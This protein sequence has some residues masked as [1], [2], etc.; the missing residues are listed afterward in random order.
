MPA[1]VI[2]NWTFLQQ[3]LW[4][5]TLMFVMFLLSLGVLA[6]DKRG[7]ARRIFWYSVVLL[8]GVVYNPYFWF[9]F[10]NGVYEGDDLVQLRLPWMVPALLIMAYAMSR[11]AFIAKKWQ[12]AVGIAAGFV[13][14][15]WWAGVPFHP[16]VVVEKENVYK[17]S[18]DAKESADAVLKDMKENPEHLKERPGLMEFNSTDYYDDIT[19]ANL[20]HYGIRQ[21]TSAFTV[22]PALVTEETY[23]QEGFSVTG[24][25]N[26]PIQYLVYETGAEQIGESAKLYGYSELIRTENHV[27]MRYH[28]KANVYLVVRGQTKADTSG[29]LR[30]N[31][32]TVSLTTTGWWRVLELGREL[33]DV[34]FSAAYASETG[35]SQRTANVILRMNNGENSVQSASPMANLND[36]TWGN[37][38]GWKKADVIAQYGEEA[39]FNGEVNDQL[40]TSPIGAE[41]R[42]NAALRYDRGMGDSIKGLQEDDCNILIVANPSISWWLE[43]YAT[44]GGKVVDAEE[45]KPGD[46][47]EMCF[48]DGEWTVIRKI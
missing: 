46:C 10:V 16:D 28:R 2:E 8:A 11:I 5:G 29:E 7:S 32:G 9:V 30:G 35:Q 22:Q 13:F 44:D 25:Y 43:A 6:V 48:E 20:Y 31:S 39:L 15:I 38:E 3:N 33:A 19:P 47:L 37:C 27:L 21:Y 18:D 17:I 45:L 34:R 23:G 36:I 4:P 26:E 40:Y 14:L 41:N 1:F 24:Y 12:Y 42:Y